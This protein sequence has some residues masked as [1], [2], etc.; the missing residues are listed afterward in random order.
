MK[1]ETEH[2]ES[3]Q[4]AFIGVKPHA[5]IRHIS[6][7]ITGE[8]EVSVNYH[9]N[10]EIDST[11][12][13]YYYEMLLH[14]GAVIADNNPECLLDRHQWLIDNAYG[15]VVVFGL[16]LGDSLS[17]LLKKQAAGTVSN[18]LIIEKEQAIIDLVSP[19]FATYDIRFIQGDVFTF[20][21]VGECDTIYYAIWDNAPDKHEVDV[22]MQRYE[23]FCMQQGFIYQ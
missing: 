13:D 2:L 17:I 19:A 20:T 11:D 23:Q 5:D 8:F 14:R 4:D 22:L 7:G 3:L 15:N 10:A 16:G 18:I 6:T 9:L 1:R 12:N 21:P